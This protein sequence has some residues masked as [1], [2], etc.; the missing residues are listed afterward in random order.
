MQ[1]PLA[2]VPARTLLVLVSLTL[3]LPLT[4][5]ASLL[6]DDDAPHAGAPC[7]SEEALARLIEGNARFVEGHPTQKT[8][9]EKLAEL[10]LG[11]HPFA[12][13][14]GCSDSRVPIELLFDQGFGDLFVIR[15][16]GNVVDE[17][18]QGTFEYAV[19][20][21][22]TPLIV[23]LGHEHCGAVT[24]ALTADED[25]E[26]VGIRHLLHNIGPALDNVD[27]SQP[28]EEQITCG[29]EANVRQSIDRILHYGHH[30][31]QFEHG[32]FEIIGAVYDLHTHKVRYLD[33]EE[34]AEETI[35]EPTSARRLIGR[36]RLRH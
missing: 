7:T 28:L 8:T 32:D 16:A 34:E 2:S 18:V 13:I 5:S 9:E 4:F 20:H 6:A 11:Q 19:D 25:K 14:L 17:D 23:V 22:H 33:L 35:P 27:R 3:I 31:E 24:A 26:P 15:L 1:I 30:L 29:V 10:E 21:L 36:P 12:T